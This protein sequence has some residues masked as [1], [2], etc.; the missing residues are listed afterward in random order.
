MHLTKDTGKPGVVAQAANP[1][2]RRLRQE[3]LKSETNLGH[4]SKFKAKLGYIIKPCLK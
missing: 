1:A 3:N 4:K 2:L